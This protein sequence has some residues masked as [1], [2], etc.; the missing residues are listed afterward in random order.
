MNCN[1]SRAQHKE[2]SFPGKDLAHEKPHTYY[3]HSNFLFFS[4]KASSSFALGNFDLVSPRL[5]T[6]KLQF[7]ADAK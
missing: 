7:S 1:N 2:D 6:K 4:A 3:N 5:Q